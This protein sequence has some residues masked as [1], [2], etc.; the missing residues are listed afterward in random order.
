MAKIRTICVDTV[1]QI[2]ENQYM[3][4]IKKPGHDE[5]KDYS[6]DLWVFMTELSSLGFENIL[7]IGP[8]GTGKSSGMMTLPPKT[9]IW[10][11][12]DNK[13]P[14]WKGG[15]EEYGRKDSPKAP[16]HLVPNSYKDIIDHIK[17]GLERGMFEEE[18]Y[19]IITGHTENFKEGALQRVRL[20]TLGKLNNKMQVEAKLETVLYSSVTMDNGNPTYLLE[21][22]NNGFNTCRSPMGAFEGKIPNDYKL[23]IDTLL[24]Y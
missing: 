20:K 5:W 23:I 16:Y 22:Q 3:S 9:N 8:P 15:K 12:V 13:N 14:V 24:N 7:I 11:N 10:F 1:T 21:T 19:A 17:V 2:Q 4:E 6:Q 18:K